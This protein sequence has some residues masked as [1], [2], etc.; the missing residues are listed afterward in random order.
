MREM[1]LRA[2]VFVIA[3]VLSIFWRPRVDDLHGKGNVRKC[4][5]RR[6]TT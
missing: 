5:E 4:Q 6:E 1:E 3:D 2:I